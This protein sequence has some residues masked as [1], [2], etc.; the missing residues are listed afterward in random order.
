MNYYIV[1]F[2]TD[3]LDEK[4]MVTS[5]KT[6][7]PAKMSFVKDSLPLQEVLSSL[8]EERRENLMNRCIAKNSSITLQDI[9]WWTY[10]PG[11]IN[12]NW[13]AEFRAWHMWRHVA[14]SKY[15]YMLWL[16]SDTFATRKWDR[17]PVSYMISNDLVVFAGHH[18]GGSFG[19]KEVQK[20]I[21]KSFN[22]TLCEAYDDKQKGMMISKTGDD[23]FGNHLANFH[24]YYHI[25]NLDFYRSD[26]VD[27]WVR[28]WIGDYFLCREY[29]DQ[30]ALT[31]P[32]FILAPE[33]SW[34]MP[35]HNFSMELF[36]NNQIDVGK[37]AGGFIKLWKKGNNNITIPFPEARGNC[38]INARS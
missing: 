15:K 1:V 28:N 27:T 38:V 14:L 3:D 35:T 37:R 2:Y 22:T 24:G 34:T 21:F 16:D 19:G 31:V 11:R 30:A 13:Q 4:D 17:D 12:Y 10:C 7:Y 6:M 20:R 5:R 29:D 23:C 36:H 18:G 26:M 33:R 32:A 25:T 8:P 9:D